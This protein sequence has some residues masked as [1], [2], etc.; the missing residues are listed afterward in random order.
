M[1]GGALH[2]PGNRLA[3]H[4]Y[5]TAPLDYDRIQTKND[6]NRVNRNPHER[7]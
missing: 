2:T 6:G 1:I 5:Q 7:V 4:K 3:S